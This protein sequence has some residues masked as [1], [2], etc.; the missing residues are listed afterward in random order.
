MILVHITKSLEAQLYLKTVY[1]NFYHIFCLFVCFLSS[2]PLSLTAALF[3]ACYQ[4]PN[5]CFTFSKIRNPELHISLLKVIKLIFQQFPVKI[6]LFQS[7]KILLRPV[8][9]W[10]KE[11]SFP[12]EAQTNQE[13]PLHVVQFMW[14]NPPNHVT[15]TQRKEA[16]GSF[17]G[18]QMEDSTGQRRSTKEEW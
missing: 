8:F 1:W 14:F 7:P 6:L 17:L 15:A 10:K 13:P 11:K 5:L 16:N 18:T 2:T 3:S 12:L 9:P 4:Q